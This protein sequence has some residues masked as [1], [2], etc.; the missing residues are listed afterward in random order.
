MV[1][2]EW[3]NAWRIPSIPREVL[4]GPTEGEAVQ[5]ETQ[6]PQ[7]QVPKKP[8]MGQNKS[9]Q[10]DEGSKQKRTQKGQKETI[11]QSKQAKGAHEIAPNPITQEQ[12]GTKRP[13]VHAAGMCKKS[14]VQWASLDYTITKDN[15][16]M[17]A[18]MVQDYLAEDFNHTTHHMDN[19]QEQLAEIG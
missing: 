11:E 2:S 3:P 9:T 15:G 10:V 6:P 14:K 17:I 18:R 8:R 1:I 12:G 7:I 5:A 13:Y 4:E 19:L 16:E